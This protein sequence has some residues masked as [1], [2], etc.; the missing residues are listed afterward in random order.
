MDH[1][2]DLPED[3]IQP[4]HKITGMAELSVG[5]MRPARLAFP[6]LALPTGFTQSL[7]DLGQQLQQMLEPFIRIGQQLQQALQPLQ[8]EMHRTQRHLQLILQPF[9]IAAPPSEIFGEPPA[10]L[11]WPSHTESTE[12]GLHRLTLPVEIGQQLAN[13]GQQWNRL[14]PPTSPWPV[15]E[16]RE[17]LHGQQQAWQR[18]FAVD[19]QARPEYYRNLRDLMDLIH[20]CFGDH[21]RLT[22]EAYEQAVD[23]LASGVPPK[24]ADPRASQALKQI[25]TATG[26]RPEDI[27][28]KQIFPAAVLLVIDAV[29]IPQRIQLGSQRLKDDAGRWLSTPPLHLF[30]YQY[31]QFFWQQI[32][33]AA[34]A[35][36]L[37]EPYP[38]LE[39]D[40]LD[41]S[42]ARTASAAKEITAAGKGFAATSLR[43]SLE[44]AVIEQNE[45]YGRDSSL[46]P[47]PETHLEQKRLI[48]A[49][50][51]AAA[52]QERALLRLLRD[53]ASPVEVRAEMGISQTN[54]RQVLHRLRKKVSGLS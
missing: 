10:I 38:R 8:E 32:R 45:R 36:L 34:K 7:H 44:N 39:R 9:S 40:L 43:A 15:K 30:A 3:P 13:L 19:M 6:T 33:N 52:P 35:I 53:G 51:A 11:A 28:R 22:S 25:A 23:R 5:N 54:Y 12:L 41:S 46:F 48:A 4:I 1:T 27:L 17:A 2:A 50:D 47:T 49:L 18:R 21:D 16:L 37:N 31:A 14:I 42:V 29:S 20:I 24:L 26:K